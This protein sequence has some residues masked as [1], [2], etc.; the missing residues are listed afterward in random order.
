MRTLFLLGS[1]LCAA[2]GDDD[3][4]RDAAMNVDAR[5]DARNDGP[6]ADVRLDA[7][8]DGGD[9]MPMIAYCPDDPPTDA[10]SC[11]AAQDCLWLRCETDGEIVARCDG[12]RWTVTMR[13][14]METP[15]GISG[16][17]CMPDQICYEQSSG[18]LMIEC[19]DNPC[20]EGPIDCRCIECPAGYACS[21]IG[22]N[23]Y[24]RDPSGAP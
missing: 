15:C 13:P 8:I 9:A 6:G 7:L 19:R 14:C 20:R 22:R 5:G 23:A 11:S 4:V 3:D 21:A 16:E 12:A 10:A 24:C 1:L 2:C 18:A 17:A